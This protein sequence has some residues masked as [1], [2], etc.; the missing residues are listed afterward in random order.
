MPRWTAALANGT[1]GARSCHVRDGACRFTAPEVAI[2]VLC[3]VALG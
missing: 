1:A 3:R 2:Y